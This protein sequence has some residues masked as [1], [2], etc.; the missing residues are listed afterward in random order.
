MSFCRWGPI[1]PIV[2]KRARLLDLYLNCFIIADFQRC[3]KERGSEL[4]I[5][6]K[7][8]GKGGLAGRYESWGDWGG[9][10]L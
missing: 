4:P 6:E 1:N 5:I 9:K 10:V 8:F 7:T 2:E 3:Q